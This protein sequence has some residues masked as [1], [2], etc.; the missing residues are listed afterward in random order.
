M[1]AVWPVIPLL[2]ALKGAAI[3]YRSY[4][5]QVSQGIALSLAHPKPQKLA[6]MTF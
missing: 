1:S 6:E 5:H 4:T 2:V 3:P